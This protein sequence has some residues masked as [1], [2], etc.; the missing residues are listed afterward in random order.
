MDGDVTRRQRHADGRTEGLVKAKREDSGHQGRAL[1]DAQF[2]FRHPELPHIGL[3]GHIKDRAGH[4]EVVI[5]KAQ[6]EAGQVQLELT[7][8]HLALVRGEG[9]VDG[10]RAGS[11]HCRQTVPVIDEGQKGGKVEIGDVGTKAPRPI[12]VERA[13][14]SAENGLAANART[15]LAGHSRFPR[16]RANFEGDVLELPEE[17]V[18]RIGHVD[19]TIANHQAGKATLRRLL[20]QV[21]NRQFAGFE[22]VDQPVIIRAHGRHDAVIEFDA[23]RGNR[24]GGKAVVAFQDADRRRAA[25]IAFQDFER[26]R[27]WPVEV[28]DDLNMGADNGNGRARLT[29]QGPCRREPDFEG[30]HQDPGAR[31][32]VGKFHR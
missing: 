15:E 28:L 24:D 14:H 11:A 29:E 22:I 2:P 1:A 20:H 4:R 25:S 32:A 26:A 5:G 13:L 30:L 8:D 6:V 17:A 31:L 23:F 7:A 18:K 12:G 27:S 16:N 3:P 10:Q 19:V 21:G 9:H